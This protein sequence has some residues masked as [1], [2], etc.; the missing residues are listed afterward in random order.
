VVIRIDSSR[1]D[2]TLVLRVAGSVVGPD[3]AVLRDSVARQ[4]LP[5]QIDLSGVQFVDAE[6]ANELVGL[7]ARGA[8]LVRTQPFIELLLRTHRTLPH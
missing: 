1:E 8:I 6:G 4:G 3:V 5:D 7:E 2:S